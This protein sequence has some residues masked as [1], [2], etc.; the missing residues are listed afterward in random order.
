MTEDDENELRLE[1][2]IRDV[3]L[4]RKQVV[5]ETPRNI[6]LVVGSAVALA[7]LIFGLLGYKIGQTPP[8][9]QPPI[10]IQMPAPK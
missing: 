3:Q 9:Q 2:M 6:A 10:I 4:L 7:A 8:P 1:S 5:W